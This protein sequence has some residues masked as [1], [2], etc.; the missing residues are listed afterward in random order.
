LHER[1]N[2]D[3]ALTEA[4]HLIANSIPADSKGYNATI[5]SSFK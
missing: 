1:S 4:I 2:M 5:M 3:R